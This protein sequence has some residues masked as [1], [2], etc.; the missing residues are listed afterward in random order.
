M[1]CKISRSGKS[2]LTL[3]RLSF[4][5]FTLL[6]L[7]PANSLPE[8]HHLSVV[9]LTSSCA[10]I[11]CEGDACGQVSLIWVE[12]KQQYKAQN[13]SDHW[14]RV[15][16]ANMAADVNACIAPGKEDYL[17]ILACRGAL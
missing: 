9:T 1:Q 13:S 5:A 12:D 10:A 7:F 2:S 14:V 3:L 15:R 4:V 6:V 8:Q 17:P 11:D 16:A